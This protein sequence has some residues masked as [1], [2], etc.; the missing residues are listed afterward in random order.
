MGQKFIKKAKNDQL[1]E[2]EVKQC[3]QIG[4]KL[5]KSAKIEKF[6]W[7]ILGDFQTIWISVLDN[8]EKLARLYW[9]CILLSVR[10]YTLHKSGSFW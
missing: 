6:K 1:D 10:D 7:D 9:R 4:L 5:M 2:F 8:S 3:Y